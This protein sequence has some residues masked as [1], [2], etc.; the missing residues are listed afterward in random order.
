[1]HRGSHGDATQFPEVC[2]G[3]KTP[4]PRSWG[5]EPDTVCRPGLYRKH[6][7]L[8]PA[9]FTFALVHIVIQHAPPT[10]V[11][12]NATMTDTTTTSWGS[13]YTIYQSQLVGNTNFPSDWT[14][15]AW[16]DTSVFLA[17]GLPTGIT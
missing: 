7:I 1:M 4:D 8:G 6:P 10:G 3:G 11:D 5:Q 2:I 13:Q 14:L 12:N 16:N 17:H 9:H 15:E